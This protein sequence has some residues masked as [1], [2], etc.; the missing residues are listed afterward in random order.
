MRKR[1][2]IRTTKIAGIAKMVARITRIAR[3][4]KARKAAGTLREIVKRKL[5]RTKIR[6]KTTKKAATRME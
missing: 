5:T 6:Q 2:R 1:R 3:K 4:R